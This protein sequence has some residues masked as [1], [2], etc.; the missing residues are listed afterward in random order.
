[1]DVQGVARLARTLASV[2]LL[3]ALFLAAPSI[4]QAR[5]VPTTLR[6]SSHTVSTTAVAIPDTPVLVTNLNKPPSGFKLTAAEV[7]GIA[8]RNV[9]VRA[10]LR[11]HRDAIP[12]EYTK[13]LGQWQVSWFSAGRH[14]KELLQV[15]VDD[16]TGKVTQVWTGYQV[17]WTM[18]RGYPGAF[19]ERVNAVYIWLPLCVLFIAPFLPWRRRRFSLLHLD[20][21]MLLFFS[22]SLAFFNHAKIGL[23]VPL[24]YPP[25]LYL[26]VRMLLLAFGRGRPREPLRLAVPA[27]WLVVAL[28]FLIGFRGGLDIVNGNV[29]DVGYAGVIG[30]NKVIHGEKLYGNWP[31]DNAYG[32]TYGPVNYSAGAAPG[33]RSRRRTRPRSRSTC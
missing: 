20:L 17:A 19:G 9:K 15:Y 31:S 33:I 1:V 16:Y 26:L 11:R 3:T 5:H 4:A 14:Q 25:L 8:A 7:E 6:I 22:V 13:G 12:Y 23:S 2:A 27:S 21:A 28:V 30:A 18:A 29:I 10:E 24:A 32:D